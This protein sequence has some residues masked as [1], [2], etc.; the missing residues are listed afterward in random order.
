MTTHRSRAYAHAHLSA[1]PGTPVACADEAGMP[2]T[3]AQSV[4]CAPPSAP[5]EDG[6]SA[7]QKPQHRARYPRAGQ[8][9]ACRMCPS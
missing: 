2:C 3:G 5:A 4:A 1:D 9:G 8:Q 7:L 6:A